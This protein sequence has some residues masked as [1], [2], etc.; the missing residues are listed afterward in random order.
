MEGCFPLL[1]GGEQ[2]EGEGGEAG[3]TLKSN[4]LQQREVI[5]QDRGQA[6]NELH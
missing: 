3:G 6:I 2:C 1:T 5:P 4:S